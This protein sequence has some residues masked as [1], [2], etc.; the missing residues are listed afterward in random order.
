MRWEKFFNLSEL[1]DGF[2]DDDGAFSPLFVASS[3]PSSTKKDHKF[4]QIVHER[5]T[6]LYAYSLNELAS[7][8][9]LLYKHSPHHIYDDE[10][11]L[12]Q[13]LSRIF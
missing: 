6:L 5:F 8:S 9:S 3:F 2:N 11:V 10:H 13:R 7:L 4:L 12:R 1:R